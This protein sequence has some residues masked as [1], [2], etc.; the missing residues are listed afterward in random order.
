MLV[1]GF[2]YSPCHG[3]CRDGSK[4]VIVNSSDLQRY[5]AAHDDHR[6]RFRFLTPARVPDA[7]NYET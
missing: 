6:G 1:A 4:N 7:N 2:F 3:S 5:A